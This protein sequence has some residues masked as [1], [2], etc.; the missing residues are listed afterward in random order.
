MPPGVRF[1]TVSGM[2]SAID[3]RSLRMAYGAT[4]VV[5]GID[6]S[7]G[8]G[9]V[10]AVLGPNGAGKTTTIEIL[11][12]L[13][14]RTGGDVDVL[15][16]DPERAGASWRERIGVVLQSSSPEA[17]LTAAET[18]RL[19]AGFYATP[20][21]VDHLLELCGLQDQA[22][23]RNKRLSGGQQRRLDVALALVGN[24][25]LLFLDE[26]TTGF[27]PAA[28]RGAWRMIEGLKALG[29]TIVL[30]THYLEEAEI[31]AD[32][33]AVVVR[34]HIVADGTP[35]EL[36]G[37][38]RAATT[39]TFR[40]AEGT[41][42]PAGV[43]RVEGLF[44]LETEDPTRVLHEISG[45]AIDRDLALEDVEVRRPSLEDVYLQLTKEPAVP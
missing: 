15:G 16:V 4:E 24:P 42:G 27:D 22:S 37:R 8:S 38:D 14:R 23:V 6:L 45:W 18:L 17:E 39:V 7:V 40:L 9:E 26:P 30:T 25:E 20:A 41:P 5:H 34:G 35:A 12:G 3:V 43:E 1:R 28:R 11:E 19:Y 21:P 36:G 32:R 33:I 2:E 29:T 44:R 10:F 31:L 13:R